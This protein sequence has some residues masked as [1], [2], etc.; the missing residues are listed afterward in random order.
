MTKYEQLIKSI[1]EYLEEIKKDKPEEDEELR[2]LQK[3]ALLRI[4]KE[5]ESFK[6]LLFYFEKTRNKD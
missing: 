5:L 3:N 6:L 4:E 1:D 2:M